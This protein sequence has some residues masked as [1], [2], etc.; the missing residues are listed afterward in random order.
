[1]ADRYFRVVAGKHTD[2]NL[3]IHVKDE[4][5]VSQD[6]LAEMFVNKFVELKG[7]EV[8]QAKARLKRMNTR[9]AETLS[10]LRAM[11]QGEMEDNE[12]TI[13]ESDRPAV[14]QE[15]PEEEPT[16]ESEDLGLVNAFGVDVTDKF[17]GAEEGGL[18]VFKDEDGYTVVDNEDLTTA[19]NDSTFTNKK[20]AQ[21]FVDRNVKA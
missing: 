5:V 6:N 12:G 17:K 16:T 11:R 21:K 10:R 9:T 1:M 13:E 2:E 18:R 7:D 19:I 3:K 8:V 20:D 14:V 4:I 15:L